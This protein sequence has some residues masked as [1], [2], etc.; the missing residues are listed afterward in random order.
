MSRKIYQYDGGDLEVDRFGR[1]WFV[2]DDM[3]WA[4]IQDG[5]AWWQRP[6]IARRYPLEP[7]RCGPTPTFPVLGGFAGPGGYCI[8]TSIPQWLTSVHMRGRWVGG[9]P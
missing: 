3:N 2:F 7:Y 6:F 5:A 4:K 1:K 9:A 8:P